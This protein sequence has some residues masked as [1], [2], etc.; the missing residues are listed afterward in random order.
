LRCAVSPWQRKFIFLKSASEKENVIM[1]K[2][3]MDDLELRAAEALRTVLGQV[4]VV[5][6]KEIRRESKGSVLADVDVLGHRHTLACEVKANSR[7]EDLRTALHR[8]TEVR[9]NVIPVV[10]APYLSDEAQSVC[11]ENHTGFLDLKG[12]AR[13]NLGEV[14]IGKRAVSSHLSIEPESRAARSARPA[15]P[16]A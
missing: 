7:P 13:L 9:K 8:L 2:S 4:S 6:L 12:N 15:T 11:K 14:F 5:K 3:S 1:K 16:A 10:I